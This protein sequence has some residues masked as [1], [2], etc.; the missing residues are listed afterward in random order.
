MSVGTDVC[1]HTTMREVNDRGFRVLVA[2]GL[3]R[4]NRPEQSRSRHQ[5][6]Q[7]AGW[8]VWCGIRL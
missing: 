8:R 1:V 3:L 5:D 2:G 6:G 4:R 7:D